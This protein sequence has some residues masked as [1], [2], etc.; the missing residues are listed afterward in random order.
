MEEKVKQRIA[1]LEQAERDT[2][3]Q[4]TAIR[5]VLGELRDLLPPA[6]DGPILSGDPLDKREETTNGD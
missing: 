1:E 6:H 3:M 5:T 4:L 2:A